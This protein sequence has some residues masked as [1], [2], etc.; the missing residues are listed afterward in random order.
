[1]MG[2]RESDAATFAWIDQAC[3]FAVT[4]PVP[5]EKL[6]PIAEAAIALSDRLNRRTD[7]GAAA[8]SDGRAPRRSSVTA[9]ASGAG[10]A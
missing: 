9:R 7:A 2:G 6:M 10:H 4:A 5:R 8:P 3:V 1:M